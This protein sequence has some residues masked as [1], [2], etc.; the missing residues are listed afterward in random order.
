MVAAVLALVV[1]ATTILAVRSGKPPTSGEWLA[2]WASLGASAL[3]LVVSALR[4]G[5]RRE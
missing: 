3:W 2:V 5:S 4:G 1:A